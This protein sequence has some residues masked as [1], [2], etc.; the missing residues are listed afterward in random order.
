[1]ELSMQLGIIGLGRMGATMKGASSLAD[2]VKK[3]D[4]PRAIWL[5]GARRIVW[6]VTGTEKVEMRARLLAG[7]RSIPAGREERALVLADQAPGAKSCEAASMPL[8]S[9][10]G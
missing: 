7:D 3:L 9:V 8:Q 10:E 5:N 4:A 1:M 2:L 6:L